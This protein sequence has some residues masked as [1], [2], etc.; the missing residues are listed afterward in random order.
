M[1]FMAR[2]WEVSYIQEG[3]EAHPL[4]LMLS[5]GANGIIYRAEVIL[6]LKYPSTVIAYVKSKVREA[7]SDRYNIQCGKHNLPMGPQFS[8]AALSSYFLTLNL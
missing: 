3:S 6:I 4:P 8:M 1:D 7:C 2:K 5:V